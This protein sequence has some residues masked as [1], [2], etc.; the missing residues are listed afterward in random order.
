MVTETYPP[1]VNGV[2]LTLAR[3]LNG[4]QARGHAVSLV[5]P[6]HKR[7]ERTDNAA[8]FPVTLV[9]SLPLPGY[10]GLHLGLPAN[11]LLRQNWAR[12]RPDAVYVATE[13]PLGLSAVRAARRLGVPVFSGFHTNFHSYSR[14]YR[15]GWLQP[16]VLR[17]LRGFHNRTRG[18]LTPSLDLRDRLQ[19][20]SFR[21]VSVLGRGL[22][23][24][25][26]RGGSRLFNAIYTLR[27]AALM[28]ALS[29]HLSLRVK[30]REY[31]ED[32]FFRAQYAA[33]R[34]STAW[35]RTFRPSTPNPSTGAMTS[36]T[37]FRTCA[38]QTPTACRFRSCG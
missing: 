16:V 17:Y 34:P 21:N 37:A 38:S 7:A 5:R 10:D 4:L 28:P 24:L 35:P 26:I 30:R 6:R 31:D 9:P 29:R 33:R 20:L 12:Q 11:R 8:D 13:G 23:W 15:L 36:A 1:E 2:A 14:H 25:L 27:A 19:D 18:T 22:P 3:L 32:A